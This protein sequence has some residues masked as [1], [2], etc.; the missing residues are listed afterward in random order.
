MPSVDGHNQIAIRF[1]CDSNRVDDSTETLRDLIQTFCDSILIEFIIFSKLIQ[2][3]CNLVL[4]IARKTLCVGE[5]VNK[6]GRDGNTFIYIYS[7]A[8]WRSRRNFVSNGL[9]F[10]I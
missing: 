5:R 1:N 4:K 8:R 3:T 6:H 7:F 9:D 10:V 2:K